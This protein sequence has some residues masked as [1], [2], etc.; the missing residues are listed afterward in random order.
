M[1]GLDLMTIRCA[2]T[3]LPSA[4][5]MAPWTASNAAADPSRLATRDS[6]LAEMKPFRKVS[7]PSAWQAPSA[8]ASLTHEPENAAAPEPTEVDPGDA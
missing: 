3:L 6:R 7:G 8:H 2:G 5:N 1:D 4:R